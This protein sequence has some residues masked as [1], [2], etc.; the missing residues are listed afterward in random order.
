MCVAIIMEVVN[1]TVITVTPF[2]IITAPAKLDIDFLIG[3]NV[4]VMI[5]LV[6]YTCMYECMFEFVFMHLCMY[7]MQKH[8]W[9]KNNVA[10]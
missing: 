3:I 9:C 7:L 10:K 1:T 2:T 8:L 4:Q 6:S 5:E